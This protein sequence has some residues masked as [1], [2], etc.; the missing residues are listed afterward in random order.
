MS[1][2]SVSS[3]ENLINQ[4]FGK[5]DTD[6]VQ[7]TVRIGGMVA[8]GVLEALVSHLSLHVNVSD[9]DAA[10]AKIFDGAAA[11]EKALIVPEAVPTQA[12]SGVPVTP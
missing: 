6:N 11:L 7:Q 4:S 2:T 5:S 10:I 3:L 9:V 8:Q 1:F 12:A